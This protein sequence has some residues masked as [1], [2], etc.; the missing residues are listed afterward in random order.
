MLQAVP[1]DTFPSFKA[2]G[3]VQFSDACRQTLVLFERGVAGASCTSEGDDNLALKVRVDAVNQ[4]CCEQNNENVCT[5]GSPQTCDAECAAE[6]LPYWHFC[7][8]PDRVG[9]IGGDMHVFTLL[10]TACTDGLPEE[11]SLMLYRDVTEMADSSI[12]RLDTTLI[13]SRA[14]AK[15]RKIKPIC[16]ADAFPVCESLLASGMKICK[17]DYCETCPDAHSCDHTCGIPCAGGVNGGHRLLTELGD[18]QTPLAT[19][20][21]TCPLGELEGR[22]AELNDACCAV[23]D[24]EEVGACAN[25]IPNSCPFHCG[26]VWTAFREECWALLTGFRFF[27]GEESEFARLSS[28]CL[29]IDPVGMTLALY[30]A[31]C[32]VCG[33]AEV[34]GE[35][36]CDAGAGN[37][38]APGACR[39]N[40]RAPR[41]GDEIVDAALGEACDDGP[42]EACAANCQFSEPATGACFSEWL[43]WVS[44]RNLGCHA[45]HETFA[46][47][48]GPTWTA[49]RAWVDVGRSNAGSDN[50]YGEVNN[51]ATSCRPRNCPENVMDGAMN[52]VWHDNDSGEGHVVF[53]LGSPS[54][55]SGVRLITWDNRVTSGDLSFTDNPD[56]QWTTATSISL[57]SSSPSGFTEFMFA[58]QSG[59]YWR[60]KMRS[61]G[62]GYVGLVE[63]EFQVGGGDVSGRGCDKN[64]FQSN[65]PTEWDY[66][67]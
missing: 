37:S 43:N 33:D 7:L 63:V 3:L 13:I 55:V 24:G 1:D 4:A 54:T 61:G 21:A 39:P 9:I 23:L 40:C 58:E 67:C 27:N 64:W 25:G 8:D 2:S 6:F 17:V 52:T 38:N 42:G 29:D 11:E 59:R 16:E 66:G 22:V 46:G 56:A 26:R 65:C 48:S 57:P 31:T 20:S 60:L 44:A 62:G 53:D 14:E 15:Q 32:S 34:S 28:S 30:D 19:L 35:E 10:Y 5:S 18:W 41:C 50:D 47:A 12:C 36:E 45:C 49:D 51:G